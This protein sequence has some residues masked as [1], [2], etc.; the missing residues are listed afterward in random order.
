MAE[1]TYTKILSYET[2]HPESDFIDMEDFDPNDPNHFPEW[3]KK[4]DGLEKLL[5]EQFGIKPSESTELQQ[6]LDHFAYEGEGIS[7]NVV[8]FKPFKEFAKPYGEGKMVYEQKIAM[9]GD[10]EKVEAIEKS[11]FDYFLQNYVMLM[12]MEMP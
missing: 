5:R 4:Q 10:K 9:A 8:K 11:V 3:K 7:V 6:A 2:I 1:T 12:K